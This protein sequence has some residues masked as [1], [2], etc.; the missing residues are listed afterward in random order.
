MDLDFSPVFNVVI[1]YEDFETGKQAR[2]TY[3]FLVEN[4]GTDCR[5]ENQMWKFDV[6]RIPKLREM[7]ARDAAAADII[8]ISGHGGD[9]LPADVK[10]W[11]ETWQGQ[12][13]NAIA[14][15]A[16]FDRPREETRPA[17]EYLA[18]VANRCQMAF[19]AQPDDWPGKGGEEPPA[20]SQRHPKSRDA[21]TS[22]GAAVQR[23]AEL[24][25]WEAT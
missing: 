15:V 16:L 7:A 4:L 1:I 13:P 10:H 3:D 9:E 12:S 24:P 20:A 14:L 22:V 17:R 25:R 8:I 6:L 21:L 11:V 2:R 5:F 19:F 23:A 18:N